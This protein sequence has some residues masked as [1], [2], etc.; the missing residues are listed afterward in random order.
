MFIERALAL[1]FSI[2]A[3][4]DLANINGGL[5]TCNDIYQITERRLAEIRRRIAELTQMESRL[6][7]LA[8]GCPRKGSRADCTVLA[9]LSQTP[10]EC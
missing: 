9:A 1:G 2:E 6:E 4:A 10:A 8:A 3:I 5:Q 7:G